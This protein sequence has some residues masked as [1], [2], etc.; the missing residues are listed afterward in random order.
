MYGSSGRQILTARVFRSIRAVLKEVVMWLKRLWLSRYVCEPREGDIHSACTGDCVC[1]GFVLGVDPGPDYGGPEDIP[2]GEKEVISTGR[3]MET[4]R[5]FL[6]LEQSRWDFSCRISRSII[7][8][9]FKLKNL[10]AKA[11]AE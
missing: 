10:V 11:V 9:A 1:A 5:K 8:D 6:P 2:A 4:G 3:K 7:K